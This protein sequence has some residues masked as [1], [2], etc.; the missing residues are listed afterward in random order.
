MQR[1]Q[2]WQPETKVQHCDS[3]AAAAR[4]VRC[5]SATA[6][7]WQVAHCRAAAA[8]DCGRAATLSTLAQNMFKHFHAVLSEC[9]GLA[10]HMPRIC[11]C[12]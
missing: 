4:K 12:T 1:L 2:M 5:E 7:C 9:C 10:L 8:G 6:A 11:G 3:V